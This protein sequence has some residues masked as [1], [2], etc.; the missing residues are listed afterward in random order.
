M[1]IPDGRVSVY[2]G[3]EVEVVNQGESQPVT[4]KDYGCP[5]FMLK[6]T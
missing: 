5:K 2:Y 1:E 4:K 3:D 6:N